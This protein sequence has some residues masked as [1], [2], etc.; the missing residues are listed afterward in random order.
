VRQITIAVTAVLLFALLAGATLSRASAA[1]E[2]PTLVGI[3]QDVVAQSFDHAD[4]LIDAAAGLGAQVSRSTLRWQA[5]E[6][7]PGQFDWRYADHV[8]KRL[9]ERQMQPLFTLIGSPAWVNGVASGNGWVH[10]PTD[11]G[12]FEAWLTR[13]TAFA[14]AAARRYAG[15]VRLWEVW[16]EP[17]EH[18]FWLPAPDVNRYIRLYRAVSAAIHAEDPGA[19]VAVGG[20]SGIAAGCCIT[21]LSFLRSLIDQGVSLDAVALHPYPSN[22]RGPDTHVQYEDNFD[23][24]GA[25]RAMLDA[26]GLQGVEI[27]LTEWGWSTS[28]VGLQTQ[29]AYVRRSLEMIRDQFPYV[30]V[31]TIFSDADRPGEFDTGLLTADLQPKPAAHAFSEFVRFFAPLAPPAAPSSPPA[32]SVPVTG[33]RPSSGS[34]A[35]PRT[36]P[37]RAAAP[38]QRKVSRKIRPVKRAPGCRRLARWHIVSGPADVRSKARPGAKVS[39]AGKPA[40]SALGAGRRP[41]KRACAPSGSTSKRKALAKLPPAKRAAAATRAKQS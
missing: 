22:N 7:Q 8:V 10:V 21:G 31:A 13:F 38:D 35:P 25:V 3:H 16:N 6:P 26:S 29:A 33:E 32:A 20:L 19:R 4:Q 30:T 18:F 24:I 23:D 1:G 34:S 41:A 11:E 15:S 17:N 27:W 9:Q 12:A 36:E 5:V 39:P 14:R 40:G 2:R 28:K 37:N